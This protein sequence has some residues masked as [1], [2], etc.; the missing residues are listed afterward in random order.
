MAAFETNVSVF[1]FLSVA[2]STKFNIWLTVLFSYVC[3]TFTSIKPFVFIL[4][5]NT[6]LFSVTSISLLSPVN[7]ELSI[8]AS[9]FITIPSNGIFSPVFT[10]IISPILTSPGVTCLHS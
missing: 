6:L 4:P 10:R 9:P 3:S 2:F 1:A 8:C 7:A 5:D